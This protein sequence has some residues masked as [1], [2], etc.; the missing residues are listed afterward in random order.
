MNEEDEAW[1]EIEKRQAVPDHIRNQV[2]EEVALEIEKF[3]GAFGFDTVASFATYIR[4]M[5]R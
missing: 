4:R 1:A 5:K 3:R 2:I